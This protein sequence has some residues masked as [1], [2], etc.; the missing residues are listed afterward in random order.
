M[1]R[2][3]SL[4]RTQTVAVI[5]PFLTRPAAVEKLRGVEFALVRAGYDMVV[6]NVE[7]GERRDH[8]FL[9]LP[10]RSRVDGIIVMSLSPHTIEYERLVRSGLPTVLVDASHLRL[11]RI[12]VDD[13]RGGRL[14]ARHLID[15]G[16]RRIGFVGDT[17]PS[18]MAL[19]SS[20]LRLL[21]ARREL[22]GA[23]LS[24]PQ[25]LVGGGEHSRFRA[26][27]VAHRMLA[28]SVPPTAMICASDTQAAGVLQAAKEFGIPVP[29]GLSVTGYDDVELADHLGLTTVHQ[30]L[31]EMGVR[32]AE[33]V[34][35]AIAGDGIGALREV[36]PVHLVTR[37]STAPPE[38]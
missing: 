38:A 14:A 36:Q 31:F 2:R 4:G 18:A 19:S 25:A 1:A 21:G 29:G 24:L 37:G 15:L 10:R 6:F 30:P 20:R 35:G 22:T 12:V 28:L 3:F 8:V 7:T 27:E 34:L 11:P 16:H 26:A 17:P 5:V 23:G 33:R 9:E 13:I 32:A